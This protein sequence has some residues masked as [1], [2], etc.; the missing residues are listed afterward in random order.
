MVFAFLFADFAR[1][2]WK[3][4][5]IVFA[6]SI[7]YRYLVVIRLIGLC[8]INYS[9]TEIENFPSMNYVAIV[10]DLYGFAKALRFQ[11][12]M[13]RELKKQFLKQIEVRISVLH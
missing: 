12:A 4:C 11:R 13:Q 6:L 10:I 1:T 3:K 2:S 5:F 7:L 8:K 9:F